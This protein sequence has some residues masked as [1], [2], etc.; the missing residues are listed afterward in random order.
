MGALL[1]ISKENSEEQTTVLRKIIHVDMD[2]FYAAVEEH[3]NPEL[4]GKPVA[5]G[6]S[7]TGRGVL[8]TANYEARKFG[9]RSA[10][11]SMEALQKCPNL[12]F[13]KPRGARYSE[14]SKLIREVFLEFTDII[15]P[16]SLDEAYLDVTGVDLHHGSATLMALQIKKRI[17]EVTGLTASAGVAPNKFL[18]KVASDWDKPDGLTVIPPDKVLAFAQGL[19]IEKIPGVGKV[20][21]KKFHQFGLR[22]LN[23][24]KSKPLPWMIAHFGKF[25]P[26]IL[27]KSLGIDNRP[28]CK[29][30]DRKSLSC[31]RTF[32]K[33]KTSYSEIQDILPHLKE[34]LSYRIEK[35]FEKNP[36]FSLPTKFFVK[37]KTKGFKTHTHEIT[38]S[39]FIQARNLS[40][41]DIRHFIFDSPNNTCLVGEMVHYLYNKQEKAPLRLIGLG[42][43][44]PTN[45][46]AEIERLGQLRL[47]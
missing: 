6:G 39:D 4:K 8:C 41:E 22:T 28:V 20:T 15:E 30:Y 24:I 42:V 37:I 17:K 11:S 32:F 43:R 16:L 13:I 21:A 5:V 29:H 23:D 2:C 26:S 46:L 40:L 12:L 34:E 44:F 3:D 45:P 9:V 7:P 31:E 1:H 47:L 27:N 19:P 14:V 18:A 33:D 25:G 10:M 38:L 36:K 35:H